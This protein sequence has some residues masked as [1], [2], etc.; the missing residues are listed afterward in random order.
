[1]PDPHNLQRFVDAQDRVF[2]RVLAELRAGR[3]ESHWMWF[4]FPQLR[5]LG[6]TGMA[7]DFGIASRAE[8]EAYLAHP[9]LG[10]RLRQCCDLLLAI[11]GKSAR[12]ILGTPDDLKLRSCLTLFA[13]V[14]V[15]DNDV[16]VRLLGRFY[17]GE[18][19]GYTVDFLDAAR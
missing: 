18:R 13:G 19:C 10:P 9:V 8:A 4:V 14:A 1:M 2:P 7:W 15:D 17:D 11:E 16:F 6:R 3:K 5:G 12:A